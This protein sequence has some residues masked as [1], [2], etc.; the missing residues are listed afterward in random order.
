MVSESG[1]ATIHVVEDDDGLRDAL[2]VQLRCAGYEVR[3]YASAGEFLV[4]PPPARHGCIL[5]DLVLP[6]PGGLSL[7]QALLREGD[8]LPVVFM[9]GHNDVE[10]AVKAMKAGAV[11]FLVKPFSFD[12]L[13]RAL[14]AAL[15]ARANQAPPRAPSIELSERER[16]VLTAIVGGSKNKDIARELRLSER[17]IKHCRAALMQRFE[18][19]SF[20][21]LLRRAAPIVG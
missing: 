11:D 20:A 17:T 5:L 16:F 15:S 10:A 4:S 18:A 6:G 13:V 3:T 12:V 14:E 2:A 21:D 1:K 19:K 8:A 9:S 7:Q